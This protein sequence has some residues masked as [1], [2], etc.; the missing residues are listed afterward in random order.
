MH[1]QLARLMVIRMSPLLHRVSHLSCRLSLLLHRNPH[2]HAM[3]LPSSEDMS[4]LSYV[5][6]ELVV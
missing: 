2:L 5:S 6:G 4:L 1:S 3:L